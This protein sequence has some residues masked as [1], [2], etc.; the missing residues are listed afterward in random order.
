LR[1]PWFHQLDMRITRKWYLPKFSVELYLDVQNV[2]YAKTTGVPILNYLTDANGTPLLTA[3]HMSY[4]TK[5]IP[6]T[7]QVIQPQLGL[8]ITY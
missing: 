8:I 6:N 5:L 3:D 4:Q 7:T 1:L 2:Y